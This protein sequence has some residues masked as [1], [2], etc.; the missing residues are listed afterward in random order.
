MFLV[1]HYGSAFY[2]QIYLKVLTNQ[3]SS[4]ASRTF[5]SP[6]MDLNFI[7]MMSEVKQT[8]LWTFL[9]ISYPTVG[10]PAAART[11]HFLSTGQEVQRQVQR[12]AQRQILPE[13][14]QQRYVM[15]C[16]YLGAAVTFDPFGRRHREGTRCR[17]QQ[18]DWTHISECR[19]SG[20][21]QEPESSFSCSL[22]EA[23]QS[24]A[25][26]G[27]CRTARPISKALSFSQNENK[28]KKNT[29]A[30]LLNYYINMTEY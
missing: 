29:A 21:A 1:F 23:N 7:R 4:S 28:T 14:Q 11:G 22:L 19:V 16:V 15:F 2:W 25:S 13:N 18:I 10:C 6:D 3:R 27:L 26:M 24:E 20:K 12:R 9:R 17:S 30:A 5:L 8:K